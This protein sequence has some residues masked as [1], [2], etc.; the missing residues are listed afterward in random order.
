MNEVSHCKTCSWAKKFDWNHIRLSTVDSLIE[1]RFRSS[2][3]PHS[4]TEKSGKKNSCPSSGPYCRHI[5]SV[6]NQ[7]VTLVLRG[8]ELA[9][10]TEIS[11]AFL[12]FLKVADIRSDHNG[13]ISTV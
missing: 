13:I 11:Q 3:S 9:T 4:N 12:A 7:H 10:P 5:T 8:I 2:L 1:M 6:E